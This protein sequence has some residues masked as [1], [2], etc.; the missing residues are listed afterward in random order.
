[1]PLLS[2]CRRA[3]IPEATADGPRVFATIPRQEANTGNVPRSFALTDRGAVRPSNQ[4]R[5]LLQEDLGLYFIADGMGGP[6]N[7]EVAAETATREVEESV[8]KAV[9]GQDGDQ[10]AE[11]ILAEAIRCANA[12]VWQMAG[13]EPG[14]AGM[15]TTAV[16][17]VVANGAVA[18]GNVGDSRAYLFRDGELRQLSIDDS[19]VAGMV[20]E[21]TL[22]NEE[23]ARHRN[24]HLLT[25]A[26]GAKADVQVHT[27]SLD[28]QAGD[29]LVLTS[30]GVHGVV[31]EPE[32]VTILAGEGT[33]E[34]YAKQLVQA[35]LA[36]GGPDNASCIIVAL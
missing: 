27:T 35:A 1:M 19:W 8:R 11:G 7:G 10:S 20:R 21:G 14:L 2:V 33:P 12:K 17:V 24:R 30:D 26:V 4:D 29:L 6:A 36:N 18:V 28:S 31:P 3:F 16:G 15:G 9:S 25:Q 5:I 32:M 23:A 13:E 22:T 34:I